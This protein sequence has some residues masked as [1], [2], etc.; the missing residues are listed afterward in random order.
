MLEPD[1]I[2]GTLLGTAV[3][4]ALGMP[5][6]GLSHQNVRTY[7]KGIKAYR[8]DEHRRDLGA[9]QWTGLTQ[10][11]FALAHALRRS[12]GS[13]AAC[14][15]STPAR[16]RWQE[17]SAP[18]ATAAASAAPLGVWWA[19]NGMT[20]EEAFDT[21][22]TLFAGTSEHPAALAAAFGQAS[23]VRALLTHTPDDLDGPAFFRTVTDATRWAEDQLDSG[24]VV[25]DRLRLLAGHLDDFPLDLQD[26][27]A[28]TGPAADEAWPFAVAMVAR[29]PL[30][31]EAT[32]LPA[33]NVGGAASAIGAL[34]GSLVGA[35]HGWAAFPAWAREGLEDVERLEA[36]ARA[37]AGAL[38]S[39]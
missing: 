39:R 18:T 36:E 13:D 10:R 33:I 37:F 22:T 25:S 31:L 9:G 8:A 4:D 23:A 29:N 5:I 3:G 27:C 35:L 6:D 11:T 21:S 14:C 32:L 28:G 26:L 7:Y 19:G 1:R 34:V 20:K 2:L 30:L 38:S 24:H 16:R 12:D 15:V 17:S